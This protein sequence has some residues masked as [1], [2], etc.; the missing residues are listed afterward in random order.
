M[1]DPQ[2]YKSDHPIDIFSDDLKEK[3]L[4]NYRIWAM[5]KQ[6]RHKNSSNFI[7]SQDYYKIPK[8]IFRANGII[9]RV[10]KPNIYRDININYTDKASMDL[11]IDEF[12]L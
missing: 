9:Y 2:E 4:T 11:K 5:F 12:K 8:R 7:I 3:E 1:K 6:S 10:F